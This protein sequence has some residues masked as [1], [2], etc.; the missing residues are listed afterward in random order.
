MMKLR[1][2]YENEHEARIIDEN[3]IIVAKV[4]ACTDGLLVDV[5]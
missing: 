1:V 5:G 2:E 3:G 4:Y